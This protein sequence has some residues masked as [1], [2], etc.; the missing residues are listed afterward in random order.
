MRRSIVAAATAL[1]VVTA[2]LVV[3]GVVGTARSATAALG[4]VPADCSAATAAYRSD[5]QSLTYRYSGGKTSTQA[6]SGDKLSWVPTGIA[7]FGSIGDATYAEDKMLATHPTDG[8]I[9]HVKRVAQRIDGVWKITELTTTRVKSGFAGTRA[10]TMAWPYFYR[11]AGT[12]LYR[13]KFAYVDGKPTVSAPVTLPGSAWDTV[14]TLK[15]QR[16]DGTAGNPVDVLVGTKSNGELKH[17]RISYASPATISSKVLKAS[18]WAPFTS[19]SVGWCDDHP[20]G[21]VLLGIKADGSASVHFDANQSDGD[22]SDI[23]GG[24]LGL[25]GWTAKAY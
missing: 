16:T 24:S 23:K 12:S 6:I 21:R 19:L 9:Y 7:G 8:Y 5:G 17:W 10:L 4:D 11:L 3:A 1:T 13:Y 18:G 22:G 2:G 14:N 25:L 20:A 15:Y